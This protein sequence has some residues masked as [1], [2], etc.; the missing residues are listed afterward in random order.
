MEKGQIRTNILFQFKL[1]GTVAETARNI[2]D[3]IGTW[4][5]VERTVQW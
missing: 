3:G 1:V 5:G 2:N 4:S